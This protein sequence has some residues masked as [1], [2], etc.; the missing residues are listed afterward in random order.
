MYLCIYLSIGKC[1]FDTKAL[2]AQD[3]GARLLI[4]VDTEDNSL[5]RLGMY[6]CVY[7]S[8]CL[9]NYLSNSLCMYLS[10]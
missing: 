7:V 1:R 4:V 8:M 3:A 10:I 9:S 6:R 5:Q 2:Y